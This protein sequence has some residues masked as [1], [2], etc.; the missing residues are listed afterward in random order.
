MTKFLKSVLVS[1]LC[2][3]LLF[4]CSK[5]KEE[6][7]FDGMVQGSYYHIAFYATEQERDEAKTGI[8]SIF[9]AIDASISLWHQ[10]SLI[11]RVNKNQAVELDS[12]FIDCF[13]ASQ[14]ISQ[15]TDGSLDCTVGGLVSAYGFATKQR[16]KLTQ[17]QT[18]SLL[19]YVGYRNVRIE[20]R[21]LIKKYPQTQLD[22]NA[23]AQGY[24]TDK[25]SAYFL[26][27][28]IN[29]FIV[30][31]GGEVRA[32]GKKADGAL[33]RCAIEKPAKNAESEQQYSSY[34]ELDN[35]SI[36]TS[37]SYRKYFI[38]EK[39]VRH[40]HTID[41]KTGSSVQHSLLSV[42]VITKTAT[43]ADGLA[44][45]FMVMGVEKSKEYLAKHTSIQA[46]F[47]SAGKNNT[48]S[49]Y[50]TPKLKVIEL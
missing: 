34:V 49:T 16:V 1:S 41:P 25:V 14:K 8:D 6:Y 32:Q 24:T 43:E 21:K 26:G 23:I 15:E 38:D 7:V 29:S 46:F 47:I 31:V 17:R 2:S 39:G 22:F 11:N 48:Y 30:D 44:T 27:H 19:Q 45:A 9:K 50:K 3:L 13:N 10:N 20:G 36:V 40:S 28:G 5:Q 18:D 37:G 42:S 4:S 33:W 35:N 12:I